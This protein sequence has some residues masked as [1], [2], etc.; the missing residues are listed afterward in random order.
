[1]LLCKREL[2]AFDLLLFSTKA[3]N[4]TQKEM[5]NENVAAVLTYLGSLSIRERGDAVRYAK[6][7]T[8]IVL[9]V[10]INLCS[11][12]KSGAKKKVCCRR[13][14]KIIAGM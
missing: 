11:R 14:S 6:T 12:Q 7:E 3:P 1:L 4:L 13:L 8:L 5:G 9:G 2:A 10:K